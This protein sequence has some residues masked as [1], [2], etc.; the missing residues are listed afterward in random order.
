M[1]KFLA[2][3]L[4]F[5]IGCEDPREDK[6][7]SYQE[8]CERLERTVD[9]KTREVAYGPNKCFIVTIVC[10]RNAQHYFFRNG[11]GNIGIPA[12]EQKTGRP[13]SCNQ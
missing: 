4:F 13:Y 9:H 5:L 11:H 10:I 12:I 1:K 7:I 8:K 6:E 3:S 2:L